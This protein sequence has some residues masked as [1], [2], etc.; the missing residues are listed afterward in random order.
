MESGGRGDSLKKIPGWGG[1]GKG[2]HGSG[3]DG[4]KVTG[5]GGGGFCRKGCH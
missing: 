3:A 4:E 5:T 2:G 1:E